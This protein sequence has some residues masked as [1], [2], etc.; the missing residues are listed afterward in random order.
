[1]YTET[2]KLRE[3]EEKVLREI[4]EQKRELIKREEKLREIEAKLAKGD[5]SV[6][7]SKASTREGTSVNS[8]RSSNGNGH[9]GNGQGSSP[10]PNARR[11]RRH[12]GDY[13]EDEERPKVSELVV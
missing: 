8:H 10:L 12:T 6:L 11:S 7:Q 4:E 3:N 5:T 13:S 2:Q 1:M 9:G